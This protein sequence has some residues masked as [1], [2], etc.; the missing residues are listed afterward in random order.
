[1]LPRW[2]RTQLSSVAA[3]LMRFCRAWQVGTVA[4]QYEQLGKVVERNHQAKEILVVP[5][6]LD[7]LEQGT[8]RLLKFACGKQHCPK[9]VEAD[10][11]HH[12]AVDLHA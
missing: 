7:S 5:R 10:N 6:P 11:Q 8:T 9:M 12:L 1:M 4:F 3:R 2:V